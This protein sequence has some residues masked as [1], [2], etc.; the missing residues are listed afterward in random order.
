MIESR[1]LVSPHRLLRCGLVG[2]LVLLSLSGLAATGAL[3]G[4][5]V[6]VGGT[7]SVTP[8]R[9]SVVARPFVSLAPSTLANTT[10][11]TLMV[12][13][14]PVLL[15]QLPSG[16]FAFDPTAP[17]LAAAR[18]VLA[19]GPTRFTL[20]PG[21][22]RHVGLKWRGLPDHAREA[23]VGVVY[24]AVPIQQGSPVRVVERLLGVNILRLPGH[25]RQTG[26]A[27][28][29]HVTQLKPGTLRFTVGV[30][31]TGQAVAGPSHLVLTVRK[32][33]GA[34]LLKRR[35]ASDIV[36][37]GVTRS[38]VLDL[39]HHLP[40]GAY[41]ARAH[42]AFGSSHRLAVSSAFR[43][44]GPNQLPTYS[45]QIGPLVAEGSVGSSAQVKAA[46]SNTGTAAGSAK[47]QL[48]LYRLTDGA[49]AQQPIATRRVA[50]GSLAPAQRRQLKSG[51]G[52]LRAGSY[53]LV[54]SYEDA[55]GVP[56]TLVA[57][58]KA[59]QPLG[60]IPRLRSISVEH[61]LLIPALLLLALAGCVLLLLV[62]ERQLKR[63]LR[64][65]GHH[66]RDHARPH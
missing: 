5:G 20:P 34:L 60:L 65:A 29:I 22:S 1:R 50:I 26:R 35:L 37:P 41:V 6:P 55:D 57:D 15:S 7:F 36:L 40:L 21:A 59:H 33:S 12:R 64:P 53:R 48:D 27:S 9:R 61:A 49:S 19:V 31:N 38:F 56:Q 17:Q 11:A 52:H 28:A 45:L 4:E 47:V 10:Q 62:R 32:R 54:A 58:F 25:Y 51:L 16:A 44:V 39:P 30:A 23:A 3:A 2:L 14:Y 66:G 18:R 63:A 8:A 46:L 43:L 24:Q 13:V 42:V